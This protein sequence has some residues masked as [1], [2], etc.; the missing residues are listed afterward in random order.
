M[1]VVAA[2]LTAWATWRWIGFVAGA[3]RLR[4]F[5]SPV[6]REASRAVVAR[7]AWNIF[8]SVVVVYGWALHLELQ[9]NDAFVG[10]MAAAM[11]CSA[12]IG[13]IAWFMQPEERNAE[14]LD[15]CR[16]IRPRSVPPT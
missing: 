16:V 3:V 12:A 10:F 4:R 2:L 7:G 15:V 8:L 13:V 14:T 5:E 1:R 6:R 9:P 11:M